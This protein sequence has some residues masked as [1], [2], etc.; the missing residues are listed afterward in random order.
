MKKKQVL[1]DYVRETL[2]LYGASLSEDNVIINA[3]NVSTGIRIV[4]KGKRL[5]MEDK[6]TGAL[7]FSGGCNAEAV[8]TFLEKFWYWEKLN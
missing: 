5:R 6:D 4:Q 2:S 3:R 8:S 1:G 7:Y